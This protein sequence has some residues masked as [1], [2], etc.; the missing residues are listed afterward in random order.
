MKTKMM[1]KWIWMNSR[2]ALA[3]MYGVILLCYILFLILKRVLGTENGS[4]NSGTSGIMMLVLGIV[5]FSQC[6][7]TALSNGVSRRTAY[8]GMAAGMLSLAAALAAADIL[9]STVF[10]GKAGSPSNMFYFSVDMGGGGTELS[11]SGDGRSVT[12]IAAYVSTFLF[13]LVGNITCMALGYLIG[14]GYYRMNR[15]VK[16]LVSTLVPL[17]MMA[18][19]I[20][21]SAGLLPTF[22]YDA[23]NWLFSSNFHQM[24]AMGVLS[25]VCMAAVWLLARR[26]PIKAAV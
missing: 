22:F 6:M 21:F 11:V 14:G 8:I 17:G 25:V 16:I 9:L 18:M 19:M 1:L 26:A 12:D 24:A 7:R 13:A 15:I 2:V 4:F 20:L 23:V 5:F 10:T 3:I